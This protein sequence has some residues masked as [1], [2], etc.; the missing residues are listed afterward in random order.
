MKNKCAHL[1]ACLLS[2]L[3]ASCFAQNYP[4]RPIKLIIPYTPGGGTDT[5]GRMLA[6]K[7]ATDLKWTILVDNKPGAGGNI[8]MDLVAKAKPD[9]YTLGMGQTSNLAINPALMSKMPFDAVN[10]LIPVAF[11]AEVPMVLVVTASS[12]W[13]NLGDLIKA[14]KAKPDFYKQ[15]TAGAGTV[16]HIGGEMLASKAG[17]AV[18]YIPYKGASPAITDLIGGQTDFMF[19]TPQSVLGMIAGGKLRALAVTSANRIAILSKVPTV[20]EEGYKGFEATDWKIVVAPAGTPND[21]IKKMNEAVQKSL[22][23]PALITKLQDEAS[24][25]MYGDPATVLKYIR[26]EQREWDAAVKAAGIKLD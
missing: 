26:A 14:A 24:S 15:A 4:D 9:G 16:G 2:A 5:V 6:E 12:P 22:K 20:S 7:I 8:G 13:K 1:V 3:A 17:Y 21:V 11:V 23:N 10:D 19:A 18:S 25:P